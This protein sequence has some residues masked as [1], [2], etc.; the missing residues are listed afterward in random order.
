[1]PTWVVWFQFKPVLRGVLTETQLI[2]PKVKVV[3]PVS[4]WPGLSGFPKGD[5][6]V[7][8]PHVVDWEI[9]H[10]NLTKPG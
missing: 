8:E 1:M 2:E 7:F 5:V 3:G 4:S 10:A 6:N 9:N